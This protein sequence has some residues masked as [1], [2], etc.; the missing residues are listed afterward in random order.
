MF[1]LF[2]K[3]APEVRPP[4]NKEVEVLE[5]EAEFCFT[6][7]EFNFKKEFICKSAGA[8]WREDIKSWYYYVTN[9]QQDLAKF[10]EDMRDATSIRIYPMA[11]VYIPYH[12]LQCVRLK[13]TPRTVQ[14]YID[15]NAL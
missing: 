3:K 6:L 1:G 9:P 2:K 13:Q 15:K 7:P 10:I 14:Y 8:F 5:I 11:N 4:P 12:T